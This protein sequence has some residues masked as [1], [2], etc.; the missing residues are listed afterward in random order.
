MN[1]EKAYKNLEMG[2]EF[3]VE[4]FQRPNTQVMDRAKYGQY[5]ATIGRFT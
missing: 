1:D 2:S 5:V 3:I 4:A